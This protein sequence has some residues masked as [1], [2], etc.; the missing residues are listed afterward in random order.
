MTLESR[1]EQESLVSLA[2]TADQ[3]KVDDLVLTASVGR[4]V[5]FS[6]VGVGGVAVCGARFGLVGFA[7]IGCVGWMC[8]AMMFGVEVLFG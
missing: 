7:G 2:L 1:A 6:W 4:K 5:R 8:W 3:G